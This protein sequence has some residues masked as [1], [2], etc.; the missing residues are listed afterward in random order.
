MLKLLGTVLHFLGRV[1]LFILR[2][3]LKVCKAVAPY[4][5]KGVKQLA[6]WLEK[7]MPYIL[8]GLSKAIS[9]TIKLIPRVINWVLAAAPVAWL[10]LQKISQKIKGGVKNIKEKIK[11]R[12]LKK[13]KEKAQE[14]T[15][16]ETVVKEKSN[17]FTRAINKIKEV[18]NKK[19]IEASATI[20]ALGGT[21]LAV[22]ALVSSGQYTL[23]EFAMPAA[24]AGL[25]KY[26]IHKTKQKIAKKREEF[27]NATNKLKNKIKD[28]Q[29][30]KKQEI[31]KTTKLSGVKER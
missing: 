25:G 16:S 9:Y 17:V 28:K 7:A 4:I 24:A 22:D 13:Q 6:V 30:I 20:G 19:V 31:Q 26:F 21:G 18:M 29:K 8:K 27:E 5:V 23:P 3:T 2:G 11:T 14:K 12:R 10:G 15:K 1:C